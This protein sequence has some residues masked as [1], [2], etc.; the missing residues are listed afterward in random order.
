M[1]IF[2][3]KRKFYVRVDGMYLSILGLNNVFLYGFMY[4]HFRGDLFTDKEYDKI[5]NKLPK[6]HTLELVK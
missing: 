1:S 2:K 5:K 6:N 4:S 3:K